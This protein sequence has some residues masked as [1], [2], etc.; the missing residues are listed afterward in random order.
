MSKKSILSSTCTR[1]TLKI[2]NSIL[3]VFIKTNNHIITK[4]IAILLLINLIYQKNI[5]NKEVY[6]YTNYKQY[7]LII[8]KLKFNTKP[9]KIILTRYLK[10]F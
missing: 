4:N 8:S 9:I 2:V 3:S 10:Y 7:I 5:S 6:I 1:N